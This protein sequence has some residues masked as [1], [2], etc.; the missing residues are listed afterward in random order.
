MDFEGKSELE[1]HL[2]S[3]H[4]HKS[5]VTKSKLEEHKRIKCNSC[6]KE[7]V[8]Q[9]KLT[10]HMET[11]NAKERSKLE[12]H[13]KKHRF[14]CDKCTKVFYTKLK[15]DEHRKKTHL[16]YMKDYDRGL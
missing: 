2:G 3:K 12:S 6:D 9:D 15:F 11:H 1:K 7:F 16:T 14:R 13:M 10:M 5:Q 8:L 4:G